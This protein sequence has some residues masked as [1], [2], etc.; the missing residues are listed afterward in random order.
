MER[1]PVIFCLGNYA[2]D[3]P[4]NSLPFP[5]PFPLPLKIFSHVPNHNTA[6]GKLQH[7]AGWCSWLPPLN[8]EGYSRGTNTTCAWFLPAAELSGL[9]GWMGAFLTR[10]FTRRYVHRGVTAVWMVE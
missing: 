2:E 4:G 3:L 10:P 7:R 9:G 6:L 5:R 8:R 1:V